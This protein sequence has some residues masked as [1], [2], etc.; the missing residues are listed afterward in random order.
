LGVL[1]KTTP[2]PFI[3]KGFGVTASDQQ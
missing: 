3:C 2:K 1:W